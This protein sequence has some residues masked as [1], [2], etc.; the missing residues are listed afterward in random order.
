MLDELVPCGNPKIIETIDHG[1][2]SISKDWLRAIKRNGRVFCAWCNSNELRPPRKKYCSGECSNSSTAYC[3]PQS[4]EFA[5]K[6]LLARQ[7]FK[8]SGCSFD[9]RPTMEQARKK[10]LGWQRRSV[11][12]TIENLRS[13]PKYIESE[14]ARIPTYDPKTDKAKMWT[15]EKGHTI[16]E[17][18][19]GNPKKNIIR[20][21]EYLLRVKADFRER[22]DAYRKTKNA[23]NYWSL[24]MPSLI[25]H[26]HRELKDHK[27][28]EIDHIIPVALE[29]MSIGLDNV[30]VLCYQCHKIKT[31][32]DMIE[33]R[34]SRSERA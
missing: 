5:F 24:N 20:H 22:Y 7:G 4:D 3:Y 34:R 8:C 32:Q 23:E 11:L 2:R 9:Y 21:Q 25:R 18:A 29:G 27:E 19:L 31:K 6:I 30:Q 12:S 10:N 15:N 13:I 33:I 28:P 26:H 1:K 17:P 14:R 16:Y